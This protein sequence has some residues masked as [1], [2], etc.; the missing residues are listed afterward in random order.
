MSLVRKLK[1]P[2]NKVSSL[3]DLGQRQF[4]LHHRS[5]TVPTEINNLYLCIKKTV[6]M[7]SNTD[8]S[9]SLRRWALAALA[10][11]A[12][13]FFSLSLWVDKRTNAGLTEG[14]VREIERSLHRLQS[15]VYGLIEDAFAAS[16]DSLCPDFDALW[17]DAMRSNGVALYVIDSSAGELAWWSDNLPAGAGQIERITGESKYINLG[18]GWYLARRFNCGRFHAVALILI[19]T[20][21]YYQ[22]RFLRNE[23]NAA[24]HF[25]QNTVTAPLGQDVGMPVCEL[26]GRPVFIANTDVSAVSSFTLSVVFRWAAVLALLAFLMPLMCSRSFCRRDGLRAAIAFFVLLGLRMFI[27]LNPA[28][29]KGDLYLFSPMIYADSSALPSLGDLMLHVVFVLLFLTVLFTIPTKAERRVHP[30]AWIAATACFA[31]MV[32]YMVNSLALNS[33]ISYRMYRMSEVGASTFASYFILA[34]LYVELFLLMCLQGRLSGG[35]GRLRMFLMQ[36]GAFAAIFIPL[37]LAD[38]TCERGVFLLMFASMLALYYRQLHGRKFRLNLVL[39]LAILLAA[40]TSF[41]L[42]ENT[43]RREC[44]KR[45]LLAQSLSSER[46]P[47]VEMLLRD[48]ETKISADSYLQDILLSGGYLQTDLSRRLTEQYFH[49]YFQRYDLRYNI[50]RPA[51]VLQLPDDNR[52]MD[53]LEFFE[54]ERAQ[55]GLPLA[56]S[57]HFRFMNNYWGRIHYYGQFV[58]ANRERSSEAVSLFIELYSKPDI[59]SIGYPELL[60]LDDNSRQEKDLR[61]YSYAKYSAGR[62]VTRFGNFE[63]GFELKPRQNDSFFDDDGYNHYFHQSDQYNT[64]IVSL[65]HLRFSDAASMFSYTFLFLFISL[66]ILLSLFG[67]RLDVS[68]ARVSFRRRISVMMIAGITVALT[69]LAAAMLAYLIRQSETKNIDNIYAKMRSIIIELDQRL[70]E[71]ETL[72]RDNADELTA[73]LVGLSNAFYT[74]MNLYGLDGRLI[75]SSRPEIFEKKLLG[76]EMNR[77]AFR[78]VAIDKSPRY[79]HREQIGRMSYHSA[80][81]TYYNRNSEPVAYLN[82]P[83]SF[84]QSEFRNELLALA[85]AIINIYILLILTGVALAV[86]ISN[87]ITKPLNAV[88]HKMSRLDLAHQTEPIDYRGNNE[89]GD[90]V[91]EYNRMIE[92]LA[93][94]A[95]ML[96]ESERESAWR[97]MA[98]QIA[99]EI[100]NP[101]TP[102]KLNIQHVLRMRDQQREGWQ[103]KL[104]EAVRAILIQIDVLAQTAS[105]FSDFARTGKTAIAELDLEHSLASAIELFSGYTT[106]SGA[107]VV[108]YIAPLDGAPIL[109]AANREQLQRVF[110][111]IIKNAIQATEHLD[112]PAVRIELT[113]AG[114]ATV[115]RIHDNG[116]GVSDEARRNLFKPNFT[117]RSGGTGLGLAISKSIIESFGGEILLLEGSEGACFELRF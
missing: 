114:G 88:R 38:P 67:L 89:L 17:S 6:T 59:E 81:A 93:A 14:R 42:M 5:L 39:W 4:D 86:F 115:V 47:V 19:K 33:N 40:Y 60:Q 30:A 37:S 111:N 77:E 68:L 98:C 26:G 102:M 52:E 45:R 32:H 15:D 96:A 107:S 13:L 99:H 2:V 49:G 84:R 58:F 61:I 53:C 25:P 70:Y 117:T 21:Y 9:Q 74:D 91:R 112:E 11:L 104:A 108:R 35:V 66:L 23:F 79:I 76:E 18:N 106:A 69:S 64:V 63:Y 55:Q 109:V 43:D 50:C 36:T 110:T 103:D 75:A 72:S 90:L 116:P 94:S 51:T 29:F 57:R 20:E 27:F 41:S 44:Q 1:H 56:G 82:L 113:R 83:H 87:Q 7:R 8:N 65:P 85:G 24:L 16:A 22:N 95:R 101:L 46:D 105:E 31:V 54:L 3:R 62:L 78:R 28:Y 34:L 71:H 97:E 73:M 80:Y 10:V 100:K 12:A 92:E 48:I